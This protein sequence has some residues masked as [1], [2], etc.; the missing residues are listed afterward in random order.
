MNREVMGRQMFNQGGMVDP[1]MEQGMPMEPPMGPPMGPPGMADPEM[2]MAAQGAMENGIDPAE[3]EGML[4]NYSQNMDDLEGSENYETVIN[5]IRGDEAP[6]EARYA[7][8]ASMVGPEDAQA[9]PESVLTLVQPIMLMNSMDQGIGSLAEE[10]MATPVEGPMAGGIM[11]TVDMAP[12]VDPMMAPPAG[13]PPVNFNQGGAVQYMVDGGLPDGRLKSIYDEKLGL[14]QS[15]IGENDAEQEYEDQKQMSQAQMLFDVAAGALAFAGPS[16][17]QMSGGEKLAQAFTPVLGN[18]SARAGDLEKFKQAQTREKRDLNLSAINASEAQF[19]RESA[20]DFQLSSENRADAQALLMQGRDFGFRSGESDKDRTQQTKISES[21]LKNQR[22][23]QGLVGSQ[24]Q[25]D[26]SLRGQLERQIAKMNFDHNLEIQNNTFDFSRAERVWGQEYQKEVAN[27]LFENQTSLEALRFDFSQQA[28]QS[29]KLIEQE[30]MKLG[31]SLKMTEIDAT[32]ENTLRRDGILNGYQVQQQG[33]ALENNLI[34][35]DKGLEN[36]LELMDE[37]HDFSVELYD[38]QAA[39]AEEAQTLNYAF[40]AGQNVLDRAQQDKT[41]LNAQ[42]FQRKFQEEINGYNM[43]EADKDRAVAFANTTFNQ[44]VALRGQVRA[45]R[46]LTLAERQVALEEAYKMGMLNVERYTAQATKIGSK[47]KTNTLQFITNSER[48][49]AYGNDTLGA[50]TTLFEQ[51]INDYSKIERVWDGSNYVEKPGP[52]LADGILMAI[53]KRKA[54]NLSRPTGYAEGGVV[55]TPLSNSFGAEEMSRGASDAQMV[56]F[57][58]PQFKQA[59]WSPEE[60]IDFDSEAFKRVNTTIIDPGVA[61]QRATGIGE[62]FS[63]L[64]NYFS[65]TFREP[66]AL[67]PMGPEG[68]ELVKADRDVKTLREAILMEM[69]NWQDNRV[70]KTTQEELRKTTKDM[71]PGIF[72]TDEGALA[73]LQAI[74]GNLERAFSNYAAIDPEYSPD[75]KNKFTKAKVVDARARL[76]SIRS[77]LAE[78]DMLENSYV[79]YLDELR[80]GGKVREEGGRVNT[81]DTY[82]KIQSFVAESK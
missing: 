48:L 80:P 52:K 6:M 17:R 26:I 75:S 12:P 65:E 71:E 54:S 78:V 59:L 33:I 55:P 63:R 35:A 64:S 20:Q 10:Q 41:N 3:L 32:F 25:A 2:D 28:D 39:I 77:M 9:T 40:T 5:T 51:A 79:D 62:A 43:S 67:D 19:E 24:S 73:T 49:E 69:T 68:T 8:L 37:A 46:Q 18:V 60:G 14:R 31:S 36:Q 23:L 74:K 13:V 16:D 47:A 61:Y 72:Q 1:M 4:A 82:A 34:L 53:N 38:H 15:I 30:N 44:G 27:K 22:V 76:V 58:S 29:R 45:D 57:D 81:D 7:E 11:S 66:F 50:A 42:T 56:A 70:L 21:L